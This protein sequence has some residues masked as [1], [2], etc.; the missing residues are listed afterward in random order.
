MMRLFNRKTPAR[1]LFAPHAR[2]LSRWVRFFYGPAYGLGDHSGCKTL[3]W[4]TGLKTTGDLLD[5]GFELA[6]MVF[7]IRT[8]E[9][10]DENSY[11]MERLLA[12]KDGGSESVSYDHVVFRGK[13]YYLF[14]R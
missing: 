6:D 1:K 12:A 5:A 2:A 3:L 11:D 4:L 7:G 9:M 8:D 10:W 14:Y 13:H